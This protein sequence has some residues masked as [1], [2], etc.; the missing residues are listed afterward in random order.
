MIQRV[1]QNLADVRAKWGL[2]AVEENLV[3]REAVYL[4]ANALVTASPRDRTSKM[5][6]EQR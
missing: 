6:G 3:R 2:S 5:H 4:S 1:P